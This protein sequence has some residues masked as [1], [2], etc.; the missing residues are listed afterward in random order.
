MDKNIF[1]ANIEETMENYD[2][3][4][5]RGILKI[6][7]FD[8]QLFESGAQV[9]VDVVV[10]VRNQEDRRVIGS[11]LQDLKSKYSLTNVNFHQYSPKKYSEK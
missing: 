3:R 1:L 9:D 6:I 8:P 11:L 5:Y 2:N 4:K 10:D 7:N